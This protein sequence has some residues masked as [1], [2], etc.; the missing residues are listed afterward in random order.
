VRDFRKALDIRFLF[1]YH[2]FSITQAIPGKGRFKSHNMEEH[3]ALNAAMLPEFD[4][5]MAGTRKTLE[6]VPDDKFDWKP[7]PKS[8]TVRQL[9]VHLALFPSWMID[10][11]NKSSFDYAPEGGEAYQPPEVNS[12]QD[13]LEIFDRDV[14]KAREALQAASD[15]QLMETWSLLAGG[16]TVFAMPRVAVLRGMVMN[17]MIH[18][19]A[20][21]GVYLRLNDIPVPALYGP[22]A[23][24]QG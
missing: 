7:H 16:K 6:R 8:M 20:Q 4:M 10:T 1:A 12:R 24:E 15:A 9:A 5:E 19:R 22:S 11:L 14:A 17:H 21:M 2:F 3:M 23:D 18:H 13:L